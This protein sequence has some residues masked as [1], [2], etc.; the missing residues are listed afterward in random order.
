MNPHTPSPESL[1]REFGAGA[2]EVP[3][4]LNPI[5]NKIFEPE[6][7]VQDV[8]SLW[9]NIVTTTKE[10]LLANNNGARKL[11]QPFNVAWSPP[12]HG[13]LK[14]NTDRASQSFTAQ[15]GTCTNVTAELHAIRIGLTIALDHGFRNFVCE[16]DARVVLQLIKKGNVV[17]HPL[18]TIIEDIR[19]LKT[20][21]WDLEF[22]HVYREG[23]F[24]ADIL[25]KMR[26]SLEE[27]L[28][29]FEVPPTEI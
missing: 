21:H 6:D 29:I 22:Q 26:C 8:Y 1:R 3:S 5:F 13:S 15:L 28:V 18:G 9:R 23:N 14:L 24:C 2:N 17:I 11:I 25:S 27:E 12:G 20:F 7:H 16:V 19:C 10:V 4:N